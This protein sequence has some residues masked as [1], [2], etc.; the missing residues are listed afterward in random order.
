MSTG[1]RRTHAQAMQE[2]QDFANLFAGCFEKWTIAG[3]LRRHRPEVGDV[4]HVVIPA[5]SERPVGLFGGDVQHRNILWDRLD[6][7]VEKGELEKA[8][9]GEGESNRWG[10]KYRG[11]LFRGFKHEIF[12]AD[13]QNYGAI[14][15]I[16]TGSADFSQKLVTAMKYGGRYRQQEGYVRYANGQNAGEVRAC[17]TEEEFFRMCGCQYVPPKERG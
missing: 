3:S 12:C 5:F 2:A 16:R 1:T 6:A 7:M 10:E 15:A 17:G 4:E 11:V 13:A 8:V 14:L 9:Y